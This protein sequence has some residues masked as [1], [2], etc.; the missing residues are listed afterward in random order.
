[1]SACGF[2]SKVYERLGG[3]FLGG[4]GGRCKDETR[5]V[6]SAR[7]NIV[8]LGERHLGAWAFREARLAW[9]PFSL[10]KILFSNA[11][12]AAAAPLECSL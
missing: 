2:F 8:F 11:G 6:I 1:M 7:D 5:R 4:Y 9:D 10:R 12:G 3:F